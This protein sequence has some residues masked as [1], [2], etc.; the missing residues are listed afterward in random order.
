MSLMTT[1]YPA[2]IG[3]LCPVLYVAT[4]NGQWSGGFYGR[5]RRHASMSRELGD[6]ATV[7]GRVQSKPGLQDSSMM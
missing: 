2:V 1:Y 7:L 5:T 4:I 3:D 6:S